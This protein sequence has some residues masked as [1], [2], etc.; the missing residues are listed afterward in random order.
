MLRLSTGRQ[1]NSGKD[2]PAGL[3][4][5]E[6]L[7]SEIAAI[8]AESKAYQRMDSNATT[9]DGRI[10]QLSGLYSDLNGLVVQGANTACMSYAERD[11]I[12]MQID[13][14]VSSIQSITGDAVTSLEGISM[15]ND[16]NAEAATS[17]TNAA[18]IAATLVSGGTNNLASGNFVA[19]QDAINEAIGNVTTVRGTIGAYQLYTLQT[20]M[21]SNDVAV[22]NLYA[23]RSNIL[24]TDYA[25]ETSKMA[26]Y[27][28]LTK[29]GYK[30]LSTTQSLSGYMLDLFR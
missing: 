5:S 1:I 21:N 27:Q 8:E 30:M 23:A 11:A 9:S 24:D 13:T 14:T 29:A 22:E 17:L 3:I 6:Q 12:Q 20:S 25:K 4:A 10:S 7:S 15:P 2:D 19:A 16:G 26:L 18:N 28:T